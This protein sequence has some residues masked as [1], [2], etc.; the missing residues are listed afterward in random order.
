MRASRL[1]LIA[2]LLAAA[3]AAWAAPAADGAACADRPTPDGFSCQQQADWAKCGEAWMAEGGFCAATCGRCGG[4]GGDGGAS[5]PASPAANST[6]PA[7]PSSLNGKLAEYGKALSLSWRFYY[8]Q[9]SGKLSGTANPVPWRG[10]SHLDDP[11]EGKYSDSEPGAT[12]VYASSSFLDDLALAAGWLYRATGEDAYLSAARGYL[13]RAQGV[14]PS[15]GVDLEWQATAFRDTWLKGQNGV[16]FT[17][18]GLAIAPL[19]G[20]GNNRYSANAAFVALLHAKHTSDAGVRSAC[21]S[22]AQRQLDYMMG[23][24][25]SERSFVVG[26]GSSPPVRPHHRAASCPNRPAPCTYDSAFNAAGP[27]PQVIAGA[28]VGGP[29]SADRYEDKRSDFQANEVAVDYNAGYTG[30]L[31]GLIQLLGTGGGSGTA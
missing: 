28:L 25:G 10:D 5:P 6:A 14:G 9:R 13:Q 4:G 20:W 1:A 17:P 21:L 23:L 12:Y 30:A 24:A 2:G 11:H 3:G 31:A 26:Y 27:N 18:R 29:N 19:G 8:A 22:W 15:P 16:S 7:L